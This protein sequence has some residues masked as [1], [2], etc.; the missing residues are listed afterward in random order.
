MKSCRR[1]A[2]KGNRV[3]MHERQTLS[4]K[5]YKCPKCKKRILIEIR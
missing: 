1:C 3:I 4:L 2:K 5:I